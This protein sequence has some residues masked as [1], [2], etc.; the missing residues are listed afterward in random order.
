[1]KKLSI[2]LLSVLLI[3]L[4]AFNTGCK[5]AID[6]TGTWTMVLNYVNSGSTFTITATFSGTKT[7]G[8]YTD[9]WSSYGVSGGSGTYTVADKNITFNVNWQ[10]GNSGNYSGTLID[11]NNMTGN[12]TESSGSSG[13]FTG[14]K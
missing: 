14:T 1:M 2:L 5:K 8:T 10:N 11:K 7:S 9:N 13:T 6:V 12:F 3:S 4:L